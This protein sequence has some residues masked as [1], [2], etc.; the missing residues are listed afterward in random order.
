[1][2]R[3][4]IEVGDEVRADDGRSGVVTTILK[5]TSNPP[6]RVAMV[7][8]GGGM[9]VEIPVASLR[10]VHPRHSL[11]WLDA[12]LAALWDSIKPVR[13]QTKFITFA[14]RVLAGNP[15][16]KPLPGQGEPEPEEP[17]PVTYASE[18]T[19]A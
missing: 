11:E 8:T 15:N 10:R 5:K 17:E 13:G 19:E 9:P 14:R 4:E 18:A 7:N 16:D 2:I 3:K 12:E 1:M 6:K